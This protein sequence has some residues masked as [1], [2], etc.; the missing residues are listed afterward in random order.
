MYDTLLVATVIGCT[1]TTFQMCIRGSPD[2]NIEVNSQHSERKTLNAAFHSIRTP[3]K[4]EAT[5]SLLN[6]AKTPEIYTIV[7]VGLT[8]F[9][10][11]FKHVLKLYILKPLF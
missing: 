3:L 2:T 6:L 7:F 8:P 9:P 10:N 11:H 4:A 1:E 5:K